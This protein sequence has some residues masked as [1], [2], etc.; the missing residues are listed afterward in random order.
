[1]L[2]DEADATAQA[3]DEWLSAL[4][5]APKGGLRAKLFRPR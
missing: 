5:A 2:D 1:M 3:V 4:P